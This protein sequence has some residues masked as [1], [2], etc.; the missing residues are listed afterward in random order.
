MTSLLATH[1]L[2]DAFGLANYRF[3]GETGRVVPAQHTGNGTRASEALTN[4]VVLRGG[5]AY[6]EGSPWTIAES[7]DEYLEQFLL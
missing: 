6:F 7:K 4:F 1:R 5:K 3:D 2:Q